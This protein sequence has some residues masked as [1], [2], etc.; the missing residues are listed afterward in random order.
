M[1]IASITV[2]LNDTS[3]QKVTATGDTED[4]AALNL[5][6]AAAGINVA[7]IVHSTFRVEEVPG[8]V[9]EG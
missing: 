5:G 2:V 1:F 9:K 8:G 7:G 3:Q 6:D 4:E